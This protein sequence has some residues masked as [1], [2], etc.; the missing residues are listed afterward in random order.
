MPSADFPRILVTRAAF[1]GHFGAPK[2]ALL[3]C[4]EIW[5]IV[6]LAFMTCPSFLD[7]WMY[8]KNWWSHW[9]TFYVCVVSEFV[10][11]LLHFLKK[12][13]LWLSV[14][15]WKKAKFCVVFSSLSK[16]IFATR[17]PRVW[18]LNLLHLHFYFYTF[19]KC[20]EVVLNDYLSDW[21]RQYNVVFWMTL[22][23][24]ISKA[25]RF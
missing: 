2:A 3:S 1:I 20:I 11:F 25:A 22:Y 21:V 13:V 24:A 18:N 14:F 15:A 19:S 12:W 6:L 23:F 4:L 10:R 7:N 5:W 9:W 8:P 17:E 16:Q